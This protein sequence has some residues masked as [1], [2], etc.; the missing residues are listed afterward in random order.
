MQVWFQV[1]ASPLAIAKG[2]HHLGCN[3]CDISE[4]G[5]RHSHQGIPRDPK[6]SHFGGPSDWTV[7]QVQV[8][9]QVEVQVEASPL[10]IAKGWHHL[11]GYDCHLL[12]KGDS[13]S[14]QGIPRDPKGSHF[15]GPSDWTVLPVQVQ[16]QDRKMQRLNSRHW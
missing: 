16:V 9:V 4:K 14:P 5:A 7:L 1:E 10:A 6:G 8:Q 12:E 2:W 3:D 15:G 13:H 11:G